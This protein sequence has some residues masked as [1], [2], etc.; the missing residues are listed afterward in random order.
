M[1]A[2]TGLGASANY[3]QDLPA[4]SCLK[5]V[6][7]PNRSLEVRPQLECWALAIE[8]ECAWQIFKKY[9]GEWRHNGKAK[10]IANG[11]Q[12]DF[13][14]LL[15]EGDGLLSLDMV[16]KSIRPTAS[17]EDRKKMLKIIKPEFSRLRKIIRRNF[18]VAGNTVDPLPWDK[19]ARAWRAEFQIGYAVKNDGDRLEFKRYEHLSQDDKLDR[20]D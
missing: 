15:A 4:E 14:R 10:G 13:L 5:K 19:H 2:A 8:H 17:N 6:R 12:D 7:A 9:S 3:K 1:P 11:R 20:A 18:N 16:V